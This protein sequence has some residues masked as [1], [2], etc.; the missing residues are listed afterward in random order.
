MTLKDTLYI[1]AKV[2]FA[3]PSGGTKWIRT[4][5]LTVSE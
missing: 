1:S 2:E 3:F 4:K 5:G